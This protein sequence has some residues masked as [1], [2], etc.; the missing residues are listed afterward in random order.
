MPKLSLDHEQRDPLARH[1]YRVSVSELVRREPTPN[2]SR[3]GD[4]VQLRADPG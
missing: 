3:L 2:V 4:M 1:L